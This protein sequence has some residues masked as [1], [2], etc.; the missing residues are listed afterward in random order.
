MRQRLGWVVTHPIQYQ[1][2]VFRELAKMHDLD[3]EALYLSE[4]GTKPSL[5]R[6]FGQEILFDVP[7]LGGYEHRFVPGAA[8]FPG[9]FGFRSSGIARAIATGGFDAIV[10]PGYARVAYLQAVAAARRHG[11]AVIHLSETT[12]EEGLRRL[13][14]RAGKRALFAWHYREDDRALAIG[15]RSRRYLRTAGVRDEHIHDY[16]YTA[17][18]SLSDAAW[19]RH[20]ELRA[21][22]RKELGIA[23]NEVVFVSCA[24]LIEKKRPLLLARAYARAGADAS[25]LFVGSGEQEEALRREVAGNPRVRLL[26]FR[27]QREL[28]SLYAASDALVLPSHEPWGLVVNEAMAMGCAA[29][30]SDRVGSGD[31]LVVGR[32][33]GAVVPFDDVDALAGEL[34]RFARDRELLAAARAHARTAVAGHT[35]RA[36]AAGVREALFASRSVRQP[37]VRDAPVGERVR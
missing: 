37:E 16:P 1:V 23:P 2:P 24:K 33:A 3:F 9:D 27:N 6:Q 17:D 28:P 8:G 10:V 25:L 31:D 13:W 20:A 18:T 11:I 26:G 15:S 5:D 14:L 36:A 12:L 34:A 4:H 35:P 30:L 19:P 29:I 22:R 7:L 32:N 21:A